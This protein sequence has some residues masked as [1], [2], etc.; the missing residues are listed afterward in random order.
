M[1]QK[2][3]SPIGAGNFKVLETFS[4]KDDKRMLQAWVLVGVPPLCRSCNST[5]IFSWPAFVLFG[6]TVL[7]LHFVTTYTC[8]GILEAGLCRI[9]D[10]DEK[11]VGRRQ[12]FWTG[13]CSFC[14]TTFPWHMAQSCSTLMSDFPQEMESGFDYTFHSTSSCLPAFQLK[15]HFPKVYILVYQN[16]VSFLASFCQQSLI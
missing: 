14:P 16:F 10:I 6:S 4:W 3:K 12:M 7:T 11:C 8:E 1:P 15:P 13:R 9:W 5:G 2:P